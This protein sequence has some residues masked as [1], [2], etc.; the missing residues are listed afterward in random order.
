M[1][2]TDDV[3]R[4]LVT[5]H[6]TV[7]TNLV[8][9]V[10][11]LVSSQTETNKRLE[12]ITKFLTKQVVFSNKLENM[13]RDVAESFK[14]VHSRM[15][16]IDDVQKSSRGCSSVRLLTKDLESLTKEVDRLVENM[17]SN[18]EYVE[19]VDKQV[20][21]MLSPSLLKWVGGFIILYT[22][23]FGTYV[24]QSFNT[25]D[26]TNTSIRTLLDRDMKDTSLLMESIYGYK[27]KTTR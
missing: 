19:A 24:V 1:R 18:R 14:R 8:S 11:H 5:K 25:L 23:T 17:N 7:I 15:D 6:D 20:S 16:E 21:E 3:M 13:D 27:S 12:E 4:D 10:E 2:M 26:K 22:V 9:S